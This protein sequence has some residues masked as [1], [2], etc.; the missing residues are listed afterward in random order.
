MKGKYK[1]RTKEK[2]KRKYSEK[3]INK[4]ENN[5]LKGDNRLRKYSSKDDDKD[6]KN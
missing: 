5:K 2:N 1:K 3:D 6:N 4:T